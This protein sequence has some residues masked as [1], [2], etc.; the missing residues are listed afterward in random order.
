MTRRSL[1]LCLCFLVAITLSTPGLRAQGPSGRI[2]QPTGNTVAIYEFN[3]FPGLNDGDPIPSGT[4]VPDLSGGNLNAIVEA[5]EPG[6]LRMSP[7]DPAFEQEPGTN[8]EVQRPNFMSHQARIVVNDDQDAFEMEAADDF[9]IELY[10]NREN[11]V[12]SA[13]W[14]ILAGTWHSRNLLDDS[15]GD[16]DNNGVWYGYGLI[17]NDIAGNPGAGGEWSWV[18]SPVV[19]GV[20]RMGFGQAPEQA[21]PFFDIPE[22]RHYVVLTVDRV[23]QVAIAYVDGEMVSQRSLP[24]EWAFTT[25]DGYDHARFMMFA[26]EDDASR[27]AYRGSPAGTNLDA[28]RVQ[29]ISLTPDEV[30]ETWDNIQSGVP[31]PPVDSAVRAIVSAS[32]T[33]VVVGQCVSLNGG[34]SSAGEGQ[35]ITKYEWKVGDGPFEEGTSTREVSF[36]AV[37]AAGVPVLLRVTNSASATSTARVNIVVENAPLLAQIAVT[38]DG[39]PL[40]GNTIIV[41]L[42]SVLALDGTGSATQ[43]PA[44]ALSC[45][46]SAGLPVEDIPVTEYR[47]D[48]DGIPITIE[49]MRASFDTAP[50]NTL[51]EFT[52]ALSVRNAAGLL[53]PR[54]TVRV[55]VA[56]SGG[57]T[58]VFHNTEDTIVRFE[59]NDIPDVEYGSPIPTG[60]VVTDLSGNGLDGVVEANDTGDLVLNAGNPIYD[61]PPGSN[62]EVDRTGGGAA[63]IAIND[64]GDA[65]EMGP[66]TDFS[67]ELYVNRETVTGGANWG[68]LAGTWHSR[69]LLDDVVG[70]PDNNG[71]W[72]GYGLIRNDIVGNPG[73]G[74][75]W[76]WVFSPVVDGIPRIG[77][78]Q[79]PEQALPFFDIP[80]GRHYVVLSV[81]RVSQL[82]IAYVDGAEVSRRTL[83]PE[84]S[85]TTPNGYEHARFLLFSGEDDPTRGAYRASPTGT[86]IDSVRVQGVALPAEEVLANWENILSGAGA[87]PPTEPPGTRFHRGD[88]DDNGALQLTDALRVLGFLFLGLPAPT[89]LDSGDADDNG[90]LQLTDALQIL[91]FLFLGGPPPAPPGPPGDAC[92]I[93]PTMEDELDCVSYTSC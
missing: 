13:N 81:D 40:P 14:G 31:S 17:R 37:S 64:D 49:D 59:F 7:G 35:T 32:R 66:E 1:R 63:R 38:L 15:V 88:A 55:V 21:L 91:G 52:I 10:V 2:F 86:H 26:G 41:P 16:P 76:S 44:G 29:R 89:C 27:G 68:I 25:P 87:N 47:W 36:D 67:V 11:I 42:G 28:V 61:S 3:E 80:G 48:L 92:G 12:G 18:F 65:F 4:T 19:D 90:A 33:N 39:R 60:T 72:Y 51:G 45:P 71:A 93:D 62:P 85:F 34:G 78:G 74:G 30:L 69:N 22:G 9:S 8:K 46:I 83:P 75:E 54:A 73:A 56:D 77:F 24:P 82:A 53:S 50:Y 57:N 5:N 43:V 23:N 6:D 58:V 79:A 20:P 70:D 84:W